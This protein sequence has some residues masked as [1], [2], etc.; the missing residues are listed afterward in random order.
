MK[1]KV[2]FLGV[3]CDTSR[4]M[5]HTLKEHWQIQLVVFEEPVS[6]SAKIK[7]RLKKLGFITVVGQLMFKLFGDVLLVPFSQKR[8]RQILM[9]YQLSDEAIPAVAL[10]HV[11]DLHQADW[12]KL[13]ALHQPD[14]VL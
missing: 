7:F 9:D 12:E 14:V 1:S 3:D 10:L 11:K 6:T 5:Y 2:L 13:L 4:M 8:K